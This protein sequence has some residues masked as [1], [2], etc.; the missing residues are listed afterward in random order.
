VSILS[1]K[2]II[3]GTLI[4]TITGIAT[5][6]LGFYNRIFLTRLIGVK[7]LGVYQLIFPVYVLA[8]SFCCQGIATS[9]TKQVSYYTGKKEKANSKSV[10][11]LALLLSFSLSILACFTVNLLSDYIS[12]YQFSEEKLYSILKNKGIIG[13]KFILADCIT[14]II[15]GNTIYQ[16]QLKSS[17]NTTYFNLNVIEESPNRFTIA[18]DN[19]LMISERNTE[20]SKDGLKLKIRNVTYYTDRIVTTATLTNS[21]NFTSFVNYQS[22]AESIYYRT[23]NSQVID[24]VTEAS[25]FNGECKIMPPNSDIELRFDVNMNFNMFSSIESLVISLYT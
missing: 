9:L 13:K 2:T 8:I 22:L 10:F 15:E 23:N 17:D 21:N 25:V 14:A 12:T 20:Q 4:L 7:E 18:F 6:L 1:K 19:F 24:Y 5:K 16:L 3:K 11:K